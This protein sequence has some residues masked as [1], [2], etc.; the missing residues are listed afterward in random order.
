LSDLISFRYEVLDELTNMT[1]LLCQVERERAT[2]EECLKDLRRIR[3]EL[4]RVEERLS[5]QKQLL[6][7]MRN[8]MAKS[9]RHV[10]QGRAACIGLSKTCLSIGIGVKGRSYK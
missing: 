7:D 6:S 10:A 4:H 2:E 8:D 3:G 9:H 1:T 5:Q